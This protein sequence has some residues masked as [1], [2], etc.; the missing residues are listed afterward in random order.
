MNVL[1]ARKIL[2][3]AILTLVFLSLYSVH[4]LFFVDDDE[5]SEVTST[6]NGEY[7]GRIITSTTT[8]SGNVDRFKA[9]EKIMKV[10][11]P[12]SKKWT[13]E[14]FEKK[15]GIKVP[16][17]SISEFLKRKK[18]ASEN[19]LTLAYGWAYM[20]DL[21]TWKIGKWTDEVEKDSWSN[22]NIALLT[23]YHVFRWDGK[24]LGTVVDIIV[25]AN[26]TRKIIGWFKMEVKP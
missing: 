12:E 14:Y 8:I 2:V 13:R 6:L 9:L 23:I 21:K 17:P 18:Y 10:L 1:E 20:L 7:G 4:N 24:Y 5:K 19:L 22:P 15:F 26:H 11:F 25:H 16:P 3:V